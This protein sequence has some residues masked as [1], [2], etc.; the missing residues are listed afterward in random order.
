[1][2]TSMRAIALTGPEQM[3]VR[4]VPRP[5]PLPSEALVRISAVGLCGTDFHIFSG[6]ANY[7]LDAKGKAI[8]LDVHPQILGH[9][10]TGVVEEVGADVGD[11]APG[12][13]VAIDQGLNCLSY[14]HAEPCEYCTTGDSHQCEYYT[15][16]G[17]TG[18]DGGL[19][20]YMAVP[21]VNLLPITS[22]L[23]PAFAAMTE[24]LGCV[25]HSIEAIE[26]TAT[27]YRLKASGT[28]RGVRTAVVCGAGPAGNL[29]VQA[30]RRVH[31]FDGRI[32]ISDPNPSKLAILAPFEV[33]PLDPN[34]GSVAEAVQEAT[35]GRRAEL[36]IDAC[37]AGSIF[38]EMPGMI[39]KQATVLLYGQG[40]AG[41]GLDI[42][43]PVQFREPTFIAPVGASGGF[44]SDGRPSI[45]RRA[46]G[47]LEE[48]VVDVSS[49]VTHRFED[50]SSVPEAFL[51][52]HKQ[53]G[54]IK[55]VAVLA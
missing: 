44:E 45:Y 2:S 30:L 42:L 28:E 18:L 47:L 43:T 49:L 9:E 16:Y 25:L 11:L 6:E 8:P 19:A 40:H 53:P 37:G 33:E 15:E 41:A 4:E 54:Y 39:R 22:D 21:A 50:L 34:A 23:D 20:E 31:G 24:P 1:M 55:G 12:M 29:F 32:L 46:L 5:S 7:H 3:E 17:I 36:V 13:R 48:G 27:R 38:E 35:G 52:G 51:S 26:R 14:G 10:V